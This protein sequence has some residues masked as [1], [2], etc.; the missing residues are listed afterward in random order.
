MHV[1]ARVVVL[2]IIAGQLSV[3]AAAEEYGISRRH[4]HRLEPHARA[5][6]TSPH[7]TTDRV[8]V[9]VVQLRHALTGAGTD[10]G[11][12]TITWHLQQEGLRAPSISTIRRI[13]HAAGLIV[14]EPRK[15]PR[16]SYVRFEAVQPNETWQ[17]DFTHWRLADGSDV[18][19]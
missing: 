13:L 11:P 5:P 15:R 14:F 7:K 18:E 3:T 12:A 10:A 9:R 1:E 17:S 6:L 4:L 19:I 2:K 16:S 8:R